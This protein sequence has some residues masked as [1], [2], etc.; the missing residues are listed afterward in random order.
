MLA[1]ITVRIATSDTGNAA[2]TNQAKADSGFRYVSGNNR[3]ALTKVSDRATMARSSAAWRRLANWFR[4]AGKARS[5][6]IANG[7]APMNPR[8]AL[9]GNGGVRPNQIVYTASPISPVSAVPA[10]A[11]SSAQAQRVRP[12]DREAFSPHVM[13]AATA[14]RARPMAPT[15]GMPPS[16]TE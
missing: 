10:D 16:H 9:D 1:K 2:P 8:S 13:A 11:A 14:S 3:A 7:T 4:I 5:P 15:A 6:A 12:V